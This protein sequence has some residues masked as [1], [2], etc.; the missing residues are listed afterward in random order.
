MIPHILRTGQLDD[1]GKVLKLSSE[2]HYFLNLPVTVR[3]PASW[4]A[5]KTFL[6]SRDPAMKKR[7]AL[8]WSGIF[9]GVLMGFFS[10]HLSE[11]PDTD[12]PEGLNQ[13]DQTAEGILLRDHSLLTLGVVTS[14]K[15]LPT[16]C[17]VLRET[18][19]R[20]F[21]DKLFF[22]G[23]VN[24]NLTALSEDVKELRGVEDDAYPPQRK[25]FSML[26]Y[27]YC[28]KLSEYKWFM[29]VDDDV[30]VDLE[31][32]QAVLSK[33]DHTSSVYLGHPGYG[34]ADGLYE[35]F[36][37]EPFCMGGPGVILSQGLLR[38]IGPKLSSCLQNVVT[39]HEDVEVGRCLRGIAHCT[40]SNEVN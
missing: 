40:Q 20:G 13:L 37:Q 38:M 30:Y 21:E 32:V 36:E 3:T 39:T 33:L 19:A 9:C 2:S 4:A 22:V 34:R 16:R 29:R 6:K 10:M 31:G 28:N 17:K 23:D 14:A 8:L 26:H 35:L 27:W 15:Y 18:W 24:N 11:D 25:V 5:K 7:L 12:V 1:V